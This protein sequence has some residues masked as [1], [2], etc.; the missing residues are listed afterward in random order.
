MI[1]YFDVCQ[2]P[3]EYINI[4]SIWLNI[5]EKELI[6]YGL[7]SIKPKNV[8]IQATIE[9]SWNLIKKWDKGEFV[10]PDRMRGS[11]GIYVNQHP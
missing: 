10:E 2:R 7:S 9:L 5:E 1:D 3:N 11:K 4:F 8:T 6:K